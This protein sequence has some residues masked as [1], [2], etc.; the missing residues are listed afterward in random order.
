MVPFLSQVVRHYFAAGDIGKL[1]FVLPNRRSLAFFKKYLS[2]EVASSGRPVIAP[3]M[4]TMN[5]FFYR[6]SGKN[7]TGNVMQLLRLYECYAKVNPKAEPL[8]DFIFWGNV[9]LSDF[10]DVD[11]YLVDPAGI[12]TNVAD[13]R[14]MQDRFEYLTDSQR[15]AMEQFMNHFRSPGDYKDK[16][17]GIWS[18]LLPLY[19]SFNESLRSSGDSYEGMVY[20]ELA[21]RLGNEAVVDVLDE[22]L[23]DTSG[24]VFV[25]L[26]ALNECE[27]VLMRKMRD[28]GIAEFCW[29]YSSSMIRDTH[30]KSS[31]FLARNVEEFPQAFRLDEDGLPTP[32][33]NIISVPSSTGQAK[34]IP[35]ILEKFPSTGINTAIVLPDENLLI[36]V[37]N[38]IPVEAGKINV[39]MGYPMSGSEFW[40]LMNDISALQLNIREKEGDILFYHRNVWALLSNS[41]LKSILTD[42][43]LETVKTAR[44]AGRYYVK[45]SDL[46]GDDVLDCIF[47]PAGEDISAYLLE[48][49]SLVAGLLKED[50]EMSMELDFAYE[51]YSAVCTLRNCGKLDIRPA[52]YFRL[53]ERLVKGSAVPFVGEPLEGLQIMGPLETRALDFENLIVLSCNEGI[54]PRRSVS[55]SFIPAELRKGFSLPT[56]EYQ[57]AVWA[58]YFYRMIQR[59][60][61][62]WLLYDSRTEIS[63][64]GEPSRYISQM[65]MHFGIK[66][67]KYLMKAPLVRGD[68]PGMIAKTPQMIEALRE[69]CLSASA[70]QSYMACPAKFYYHSVCGL[71]GEDEV[72]EE[73][74]ASLL[75]TVF[76][77][78]MEELYTVPGGIVTKAY[79]QDCLEDES[80]VR[81]K[82]RARV[83]DSLNTF[84]I[85]GKNVITVDVICRYVRKVLERDLE[86]M[87]VNRVHEFKVFGLELKRFAEI[88]GFRFIGYIDRLDSF[89]PGQM[90]VVDYKTGSVDEKK[91]G[92]QL[93]LYDLLVGPEARRSGCSVVNSIYQVSKLFVEPVLSKPLDPEGQKEFGDIVAN[94]LSEIA[95]VS[96][97]FARTVDVKECERCDFKQICGR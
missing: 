41:I 44:D 8:D 33:I 78:V 31:F 51:Y 40:S 76:H 37:L 58:Y 9:L 7:R 74:D 18:L 79:I 80:L 86:Q 96:F 93:Y 83:M 14:N 46:R 22:E 89:L 57:D 11:K 67:N 63:R 48:V 26:N 73:I 81:E 24:F 27:K 10:S 47:R 17:L 65:E 92:L 54:F 30:N 66:L 53:L 97:P 56:Y 6:L 84:E 25:G 55:S 12:F 94:I 72:K 88:D 29:D 35:R 3:K 28:A 1:C 52:T 21:G 45:A 39:T 68:E 87:A 85:A 91:V 2:E 20:R 70:L 62:V 69:K 49:I 19:R 16:F 82:V 95:D 50:P 61:R 32:E 38:S 60:S 36:P 4:F 77:A 42:G 43:G 13:F 23:R 34:Q 71:K 75:G 64:S 5:D 90:R 15:T 59:A